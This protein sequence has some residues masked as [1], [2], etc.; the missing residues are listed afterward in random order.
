MTLLN[1]LK[2]NSQEEPNWPLWLRTHKEQAA[3]RFLN[4]GL[5]TKKDEDWKYTDLSGLTSHDWQKTTDARSSFPSLEPGTVAF[6]DGQ[7]QENVSKRLPAGMVVLPIKDALDRFPTQLEEALNLNEQEEAL[8]LA[9][10][11]LFES[12]VFIYL[13][14][15]TH[16][17]E[18]LLLKHSTH[19]FGARHLRHVIYL[20]K[21]ARLKLINHYEGEEGTTYF[22]NVVVNLH[23][24]AQAELSFCSVQAESSKAYLV[25]ATTAYLAKGAKF[26]HFN[27]DFG[28]NLVRHTPSVHFL[29]E[30]AEATLNGLYCVNDNQHVD[31]HSM[32][33]HKVAHCESSQLY[34]GILNGKARAVFNGRVL[35][36]KHAQKTNSSQQNK[37]LLLSKKAEIDTKPEL[38]IFA[39]DV[40][41]AHGATVGQ[42][43]ETALFYLRSRG[44]CEK[45]ARKLVIASF[46]NQLLDDLELT[47]AKAMVTPYLERYLEEVSDV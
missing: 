45:E 25:T 44:I 15:G 31:T 39:D 16:A 11:A 14:E 38:Q 29:E 8:S 17:L 36:E 2:T 7:L 21:G 34:K 32:F 26:T 10:L 12:G 40:K 6:L 35:V 37:N 41:C 5:P 4:Q 42:L 23:L 18:P 27:F 13:K 30:E 33:A 28:G 9:N 1:T 46:A 3:E 19:Q 43:D 47:R 24:K 20:E 22:N